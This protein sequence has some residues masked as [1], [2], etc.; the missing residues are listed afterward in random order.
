MNNT[1]V[2]I[3]NIHNILKNEVTKSRAEKNDAA[4][5]F[6]IDKFSLSANDAIKQSIITNLN[7]QILNNYFAY[8]KKSRNKCAEFERNY[9]SWLKRFCHPFKNVDFAA[10]GKFFCY[11]INFLNFALKFR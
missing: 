9:R 7:Q 10:T 8:W 5:Q 6:L 1:A 2:L 4:A 11:Y 3:E